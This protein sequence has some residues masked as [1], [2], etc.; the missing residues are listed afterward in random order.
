MLT[1]RFEHTPLS[2]SELES[3]ALDQLGHVSIYLV[4]DKW[5]DIIKSIFLTQTDIQSHSL[6]Y[7]SLNT[8]SNLRSMGKVQSSLQ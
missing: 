2:R 5:Y 7:K 8:S 1:V 4:P 6:L 3:D